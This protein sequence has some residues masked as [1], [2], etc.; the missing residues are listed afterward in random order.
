LLEK[1]INEKYN[2]KFI[3]NKLKNKD[4]DIVFQ[5]I[6]N[7]HSKEIYTLEVLGRIV[8]NDK[9]IPAG[10]FIDKIYEMNLIEKFDVLILDRLMEKEKIIKQ[11]ADKIFINISFQSL[12]NSEYLEKLTYVLNHLNIGMIL[13]LT[14]QKFVENLDLVVDIH[15]KYGIEF[16]VDDFGTGYSSLKT[17][18]D[19]VKEGVLK[20]LKI[21]GSLIKD[22]ETDEYMRKIVK[23]ISRLGTELDLKTVAEYVENEEVYELLR[24]YRID[25]A[26]GFYLSKPKTI[27]DLL[28]EK[29]GIPA[30]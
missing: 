14:E 1:I 20:I 18:V 8:D 23:I 3:I 17:V 4:V 10:V 11:V 26:Q 29:M 30:F 24:F 22:I 16:A 9:L 15:K 7:V 6:Y 2:E 5:P 21:D 19:L 13:E 12:L 25:L 28:A 27:E